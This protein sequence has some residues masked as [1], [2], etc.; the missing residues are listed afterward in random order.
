MLNTSNREKLKKKRLHGCRK[1]TFLPLFSNSLFGR[2]SVVNAL[3]IRL[4]QLHFT[5]FVFHFSVVNIYDSYFTALAHATKS[6]NKFYKNKNNK[7]VINISFQGI[8]QKS[9][10]NATQQIWTQHATAMKKNY[11]KKKLDM[12]KIKICGKFNAMQLWKE[13]QIETKKRVCQ[14]KPAL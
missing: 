3:I 13:K 8:F 10:L 6:Y 1:S 4:R 7:L 11:W 9:T 2:R 5:L 14:G 12:Q